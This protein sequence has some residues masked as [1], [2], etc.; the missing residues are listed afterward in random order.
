MLRVMKV[1]KKI[2]SAVCQNKKVLLKSWFEITFSLN[3]QR[4]RENW[5]KEKIV[6]SLKVAI[7]A[8]L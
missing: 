7:K 6:N 4:E 2:P 8:L 1:T 3:Q 5:S